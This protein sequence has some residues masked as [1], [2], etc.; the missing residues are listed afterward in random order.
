MTDENFFSANICFEK[1]PLSSPPASNF[2]RLQ[3]WVTGL[4][5]SPHWNCLHTG[6]VSTLHTREM[7]YS[8]KFAMIGC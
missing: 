1:F 7:N 5:L 6:T 8:D 4:E 3:I 2:S